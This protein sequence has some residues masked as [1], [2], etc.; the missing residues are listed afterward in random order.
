MPLIFQAIDWYITDYSELNEC[1]EDLIENK[2]LIKIFG[3]KKN[4]KHISVNVKNYPCYF[5]IKG[6]DNLAG[7]KGSDN[8]KDSAHRQIINQIRDYIEDKLPGYLKNSIKTCKITRKKDIW[9]FTNNKSFKFI[10]L[11]FT[12]YRAMKLTSNI[13][14]KEFH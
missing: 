5:Y 10:Y 3:R 8:I 4:G 2:Y 6:I 12:N 7:I 13:F 11:A 9:G 1:E 14:Q